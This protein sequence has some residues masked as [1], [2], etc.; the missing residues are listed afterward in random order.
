MVIYANHPRLRALWERAGGKDV[1]AS[2]WEES[3]EMM[4]SVYDT[5]V[6]H[7]LTTAVVTGTNQPSQIFS[8][9]GGRDPEAPPLS[10]KLSEVDS[11]FLC[12]RLGCW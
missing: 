3:C 7:Q 4:T 11:G 9:V 2:D 5:D 6:A 8:M 12:G 1:R 10:E